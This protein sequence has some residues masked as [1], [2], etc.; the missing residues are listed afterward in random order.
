MAMA[1]KSKFFFYH[2]L[3]D[4]IL[5]LKLISNATY[6]P[7]DFLDLQSVNLFMFILTPRDFSTNQDF[8]RELL[9]V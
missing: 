5:F 9:R 2:Y 8:Q 3:S 1:L 7:R 4:V 6:F